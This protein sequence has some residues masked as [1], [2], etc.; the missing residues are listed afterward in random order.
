MT[1]SSKQLSSLLEA[2]TMGLVKCFI[3]TTLTNMLVKT[4]QALV[5]TIAKPVALTNVTLTSGRSSHFVPSG[6][7]FC[8][9]PH[10]V[11]FVDPAWL[12][13]VPSGHRT[14]SQQQ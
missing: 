8:S 10:S 6:F 12:L 4:P 7:D 3:K 13:T 2:L 5:S 11:Q 14:Q 9:F 1:T